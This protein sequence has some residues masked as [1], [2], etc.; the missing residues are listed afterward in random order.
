MP[1]L[2]ELKEKDPER[3]EQLMEEYRKV[4]QGVAKGMQEEAGPKKVSLE[5][6]DK[7]DS[8]FKKLKSLFKY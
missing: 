3:Y 2:K 8:A 6:E 1:S 5:D 7:K 4:S